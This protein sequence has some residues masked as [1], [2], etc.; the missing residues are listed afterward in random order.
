MTR[1]QIVIENPILNAP[2]DAPARHFRFDDE[3]ITDEIVRV[4]ARG[5]SRGSTSARPSGRC[6]D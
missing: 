6:G 4:T 3:G 1:P 2:F 5:P